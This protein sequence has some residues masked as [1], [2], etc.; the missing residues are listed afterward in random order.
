[1]SKKKKKKKKKNKSKKKKK[2]NPRVIE[3]M[4]TETFRETFFTFRCVKLL[5]LNYKKVSK[6]S[7]LNT[8]EI[9]YKF[10]RF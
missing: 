6:K 8:C 9:Y 4:S 7:W 1:M 10:H 2:K 3:S 5:T